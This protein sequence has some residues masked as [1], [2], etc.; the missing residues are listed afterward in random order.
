MDGMKHGWFR[1]RE[2]KP[3]S[4][5]ICVGCGEP[6]VTEYRVTAWTEDGE[7]VAHDSRCLDRVVACGRNLDVCLQSEQK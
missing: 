6:I 4:D 5:P 2:P 7:V 3:R 1:L